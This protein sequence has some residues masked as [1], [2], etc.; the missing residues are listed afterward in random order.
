MIE[1]Q[2]TSKTK[3]LVHKSVL[4]PLCRT[5]IPFEPS[6]NF[7]GEKPTTTAWDVPQY[8][9]IFD[10][11]KINN[12]C[13]ILMN[14]TLYFLTPKILHKN[15]Q[16]IYDLEFGCFSLA[17]TCLPFRE[18]CCVSYNGSGFLGGCKEA[19]IYST[20][21]CDTVVHFLLWEVMPPLQLMLKAVWAPS[22]YRL[23]PARSAVFAFLF[24]G[25]A[26]VMQE[27]V[28]SSAR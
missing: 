25:N 5:K 4:V 13:Y 3:V 7:H 6:S 15:T 21:L 24:V 27:A 20:L 19:S 17:A 16:H 1:L 10:R 2:S 26:A 28:L 23:D 8:R 11:S 22:V 14:N 18:L 9:K 12:F